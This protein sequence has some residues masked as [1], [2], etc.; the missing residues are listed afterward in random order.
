M[1]CKLRLLFPMILLVRILPAQQSE[2]VITYINTYKTIAISEEQ[3]TGVPASII[4]AQGIHET[5]AGTSDLVLASNNH[6]GIKCKD[7]WYG[8]TVYHDDDK[9]GECFRGYATAADS[10]RDHSDF[11]SHSQRYAF[12]FK[13]NPEDYQSWAYG[14][15]KAGY[16]T[17][18]HYAQI[19]INLIQDYDLQR[20]SLIA[21]G[22]MPPEQMNASNAIANEILMPSIDSVSNRTQQKTTT[23]PVYPDGPFSI[24]AAKV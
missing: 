16:A 1:I 22:K 9:R 8:K 11:L 6:F 4:L 14:L 3:R 23:H 24:N 5:Q 19:L 13:L 15:K 7:N 12:L 18:I 10:Y 17:N 20:F 2:Q 21:L